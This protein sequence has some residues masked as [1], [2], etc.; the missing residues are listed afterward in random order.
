MVEVKD[1]E[2]YCHDCFVNHGD[3]VSYLI[4]HV[5]LMPNEL[6]GWSDK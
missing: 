3:R 2:D 5:I 1:N 6:N 4:Y